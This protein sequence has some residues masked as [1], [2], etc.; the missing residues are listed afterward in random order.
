M[1]RLFAL[2]P[3]LAVLAI[4]AGCASFKT[5]A[6]K[7]LATSAATTDS[8][9]RGWSAYVVAGG[10]TPSQ[11][12]QVRALY[13][14]YQASMQAATNAYTAAIVNGDKGAWQAASA[15]LQASSGSIVSLVQTFS[16]TPK[17]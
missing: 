1:K 3:L 10:A 7:V 5:N 6:G 15:A 2:L 12:T 17:P 13:A 4:G 9:M 16:T 8:A 14:K 11:E